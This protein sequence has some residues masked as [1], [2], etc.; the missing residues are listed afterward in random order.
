MLYGNEEQK[1]KQCKERSLALFKYKGL[2]AGIKSL[3]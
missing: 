1:V 2:L 3:A